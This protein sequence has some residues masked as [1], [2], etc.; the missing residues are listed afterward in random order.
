MR[1]GHSI[2]EQRVL[3]LFLLTSSLFL[4]PT[5]PSTLASPT[6]ITTHKHIMKFSSLLASSALFLA[7]MASAQETPAYELQRVSQCKMPGVVAYTFDDGPDV[8]N[9]KLL[10]ILKNKNV[11]ATFFLV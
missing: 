7:T 8:Y 3:L 2:K 6:H 4:S 9:D 1:S 5:S 11:T 10:A